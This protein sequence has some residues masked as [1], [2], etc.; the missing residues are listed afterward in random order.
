ME[1]WIQRQILVRL[2]LCK[3]KGAFDIRGPQQDNPFLEYKVAV[4]AV[5]N[6]H[7]TN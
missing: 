5:V 6:V 7:R 2:C 4:L 3:R 1:G